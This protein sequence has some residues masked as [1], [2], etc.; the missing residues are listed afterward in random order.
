MALWYVG[1]GVG[2]RKRK[3]IR[4]EAIK[5]YVQPKPDIRARSKGG[6]GPVWAS[7]SWC[8]KGVIQDGNLDIG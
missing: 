2:G 6:E 3:E 4:M 7:E 8:L 1:V 5:H